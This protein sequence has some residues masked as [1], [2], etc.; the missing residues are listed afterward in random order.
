[1]AVDTNVI[2]FERI[3]DELEK[4]KSYQ[5]S[6]QDGYYR[7]LAPVLDGHVTSL[8]TAIILLYFGLGPVLGFATT[9][10]I[11][12]I[13]SLFCGILV[14]RLITDIYTNR[15]RHF[16]YST[17]LSRNLFKNA[18]YNFVKFRKV[19]YVISFFVF[20]LG[21]AT[22]FNGF[23]QGVEFKGGRSYTIEFPNAVKN[24]DVRDE[25]EKVF[26]DYPVIKTVGDN[27]HL[28]IT[29]S[30]KI[31]SEGTTADAEVQTK[32]YEGL[33]NVVIVRRS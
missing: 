26:G 22:F 1:M 24:D 31:E 25:L 21:I 15:K 11:G 23:E 30:Y 13:L 3:K 8:L 14:S 32:L 28:N 6:V 9:Q 19:A 12:L 4:G 16:K 20:A 2:I 7:S 5:Q 33:K 17:A 27:R 18:N 29:T 10:I